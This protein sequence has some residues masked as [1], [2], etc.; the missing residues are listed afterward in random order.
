MANLREESAKVDKIFGKDF[1]QCAAL[2]RRVSAREGGEY[3][4][5]RNVLHS[6]RP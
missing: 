1:E 5:I 2:A 4:N 6:H 3:K